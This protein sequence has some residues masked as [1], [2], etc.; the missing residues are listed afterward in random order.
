MIAMKF[1]IELDIGLSFLQQ[2][3]LPQLLTDR[4]TKTHRRGRSKRSYGREGRGRRAPRPGRAARRDP[5][6]GK[7]GKARQAEEH[8]PAF[9]KTVKWRTGSEGRISCLKRR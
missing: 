8:R 6:K 7:P 4:D 3:A 1:T 2:A 5:R 9:R